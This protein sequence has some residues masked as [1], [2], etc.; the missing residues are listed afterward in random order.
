MVPPAQKSPPQKAASAEL[1]LLLWGLG[2]VGGKAAVS[3]EPRSPLQGLGWAGVEG[4]SE[5]GA[6]P[7]NKF[8]SSMEKF[9]ATAL[10]VPLQTVK[11][12]H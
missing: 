5:R 9:L 7:P 3:A 10:A 6:A 4:S 12:I 2:W 8:S 11:G 1:H